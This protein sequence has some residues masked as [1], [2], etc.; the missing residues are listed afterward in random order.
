MQEKLHPTAVHTAH[1]ELETDLHHGGLRPERANLARVVRQAVATVAVVVAMA[2]NAHASFVVTL[3]GEP[4]SR[5]IQYELSGSGVS[6]RYIAHGVLVFDGGDWIVNGRQEAENLVGTG[7]LVN[8]ASGASRDIAHFSLV[9]KSPNRL[10]L[11][12]ESSLLARQGDVVS[13]S[14]SGSFDLIYT[15]T[16]G[17]HNTFD[18]LIP[19]TYSGECASYDGTH[20]LRIVQVPEPSTIVLATLAIFGLAAYGRWRSRRCFR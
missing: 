4:G 12:L 8:E 14:G 9:R 2:G 15:G 20:T 13:L 5:T 3:Y 18:N 7:R 1:S 19:G 10:M 16:W 17:N 11:D 6:S